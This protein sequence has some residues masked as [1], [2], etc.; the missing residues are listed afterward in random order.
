MFLV[1]VWNRDDYLQEASRQIRYTN[2]YEDI[3]FNKNIRTSLLERSSKI[4]NRLCGRKLISEKELKY[5]TY[6]FQ[7]T[8][9]AN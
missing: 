2:I 4:F 7:E 8:C 9:K 6:S 3:K 1:V 5:F